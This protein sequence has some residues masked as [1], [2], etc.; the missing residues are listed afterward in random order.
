MTTLVLVLLKCVPAPAAVAAPAPMPARHACTLYAREPEP[1]LCVGA[2]VH[3]RAAAELAWMLAWVGVTGCANPT[4]S[5]IAGISR[6]NSVLLF[7]IQEKINPS[8]AFTSQINHSQSFLF[9][10]FSQL[11]ASQG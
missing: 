6:R 2:L 7:E 11:H 3:K 9:S 4:P 1:R 5:G 8:S 10:T